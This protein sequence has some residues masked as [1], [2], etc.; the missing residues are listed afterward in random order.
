MRKAY[1][2]VYFRA[3]RSVGHFMPCPYFE[4]FI[5][6]LCECG[7]PACT[8]PLPNGLPDPMD[9]LD[10]RNIFAELGC[11]IEELCR[12]FPLNNSSWNES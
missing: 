12:R 11:E 5:F 4:K 1:A 7:Q 3:L 6:S 10:P 2:I 8:E 9:G